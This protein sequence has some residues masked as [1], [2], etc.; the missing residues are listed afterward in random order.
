MKNTEQLVSQFEKYCDVLSKVV[1]SK[2]A[3]RLCDELGERL[4]MCPRGLTEKDGGSPGELITFSLEVAS[5][6]KKLASTYG[7]TKS[8]VKVAL[9]HELGRL[10]GLDAGHDLYLVQ[11]S[12]WHREKLGQTY[13]YNDS[14]PKMNI[15]HRSLWILSHYGIEI[16]REEWVAINIA[17]G[18]HLPENQF[19]ANAL[20][21]ISAGLLAARLSV[22]HGT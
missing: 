16:T 5:Q 19:Y 17:Q 22:L 6:A 10:G 7:N 4:L 14:C 3:T 13:K 8:L 2:S 11:D 18:M 20:E 1:G 9:L 21:S 12:E 15:S